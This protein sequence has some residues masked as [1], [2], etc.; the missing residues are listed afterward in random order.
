MHRLP[1][2][3]I[4]RAIVHRINAKDEYTEHATVEPSPNTIQLSAEMQDV[5]IK[6]INTALRNDYRTFAILDTTDT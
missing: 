1:S 3:A 4:N 2:L 6:R 5:I